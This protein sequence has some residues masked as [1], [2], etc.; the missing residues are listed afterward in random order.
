MFAKTGS[1]AE[2]CD[3][4]GGL[5]ALAESNFLEDVTTANSIGMLPGAEK[6]SVVRSLSGA[7]TYH[8]AWGFDYRS[9]AAKQ[10]FEAVNQMVRDCFGDSSESVK[11]AGVNHPDTYY[12]RQ[13]ILDEIVIS[14]SLKDKV[15]LQQTYVF[16][17]IHGAPKG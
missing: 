15:A 16:V 13:H 8:C 6:C 9:D 5:V 4:M 3:Q 17:G 14:V 1:A 10:S 12:Q 7:N 11:D 2:I